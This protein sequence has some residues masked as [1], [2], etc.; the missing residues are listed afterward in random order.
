MP[1][2]KAKHQKSFRDDVLQRAKT[3]EIAHRI[4]S[5]EAN[6]DQMSIWLDNTSSRTTIAAVA[7][8]CLHGNKKSI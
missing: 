6:I 7:S 4:K 1:G 8:R 5:K 2:L 3:S